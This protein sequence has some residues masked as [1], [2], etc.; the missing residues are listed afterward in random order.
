MRRYCD[1][2]VY[3]VAGGVKGGSSLLECIQEN[4]VYTSKHY[5]LSQA[6]NAGSCGI[7]LASD[8]VE[9]NVWFPTSK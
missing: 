6:E 3:A 8:T 9:G 5:L 4:W 2:E 7:F 1:E